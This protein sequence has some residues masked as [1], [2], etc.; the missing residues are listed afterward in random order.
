MVNEPVDLDER[1]D[2]QVQKSIEIRRRLQ[3]FQDDLVVSSKRQN[4]LEI[5]LLATPAKTWS[6]VASKALYLLQLFSETPDS[7]ISGRK[8]LIAHTILDL[9]RLRELPHEKT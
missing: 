2:V 8:E 4:E 5:L 1:R 3:E 9:E 7:Q 6:D